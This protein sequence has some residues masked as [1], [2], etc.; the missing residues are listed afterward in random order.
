MAFCQKTRS[1]TWNSQKTLRKKG[2]KI[3][4]GWFSENYMIWSRV[5]EYGTRLWMSKCYHGALLISHVSPAYGLYWTMV[6][7]VSLSGFVI[8]N[9]T[10]WQDSLPVG[11]KNTLPLPILMD[12]G[13][14]LWC[15]DY[16]TLTCDEL[17]QITKLPYKSLVRCLLYLSIGMCPNITYSVQQLSQYLNC[18]MYTNWNAALRVVCYLSGMHDYRLCLGGNSPISITWVHWFRSG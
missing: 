2:R 13:L 1:N 8:S 4:Y 14:K 5:G 11:H 15:T 17:E 12:P 6:P 18:Y 10:N 9:H 3:G 16:K 7:F